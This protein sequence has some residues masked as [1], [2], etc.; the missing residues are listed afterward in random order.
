MTENKQIIPFFNAQPGAHTWSYR[1]TASDT[2]N[3]EHTIQ[4]LSAHS[5][6]HAGMPL[7]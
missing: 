6:Y 3:G 5:I 1:L 2:R 7:L 4:N